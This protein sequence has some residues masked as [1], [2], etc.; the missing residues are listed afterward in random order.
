MGKGAVWGS[1]ADAAAVPGVLGEESVA[2]LVEPQQQEFTQLL[3]AAHLV[4]L[5]LQAKGASR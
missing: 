1:D 3:R 5:H 4:L 2:L